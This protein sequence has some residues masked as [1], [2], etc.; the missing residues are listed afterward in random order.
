MRNLARCTSNVLNPFLIS[1]VVLVLLSLKYS[2]GVID[3][4][5]WAVVTLVLSVIPVLCV[6]IGLVRVRKLDGIFDNP[7]HQRTRPHDL[8]I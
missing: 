6:V 5:V 1:S 8:F 2:A 4:I 7:R 3:G